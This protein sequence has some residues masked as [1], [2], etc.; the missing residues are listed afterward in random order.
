MARGDL[1]GVVSC[2]CLDVVSASGNGTELWPASLC[3]VT[4]TA[5]SSWEHSRVFLSENLPLVCGLEPGNEPASLLG[6]T[7][8]RGLGGGVSSNRMSQSSGAAW[9]RFERFV[10]PE[11]FSG[12]VPISFSRGMT[13]ISLWS[14]LR[15]F[16]LQDGVE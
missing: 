2:P 6:L 15:Y 9:T 8:A 16:S 5:E 11:L 3:V 14:K 1:W 10:L 4:G 7:A 12:L 13:K